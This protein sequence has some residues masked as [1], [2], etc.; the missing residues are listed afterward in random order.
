MIR[1]FDPHATD[2]MRFDRIVAD[3]GS[4]LL[5]LLTFF[6]VYGVFLA[7]QGAVALPRFVGRRMA[8]AAHGFAARFA[9]HR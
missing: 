8:E 1:P 9:T 5:W 7:L 3:S 4:G 2:L 6:A